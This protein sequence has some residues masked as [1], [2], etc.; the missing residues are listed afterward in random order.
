MED[1]KALSKL[2]HR[3]QLFMSAIFIL[4]LGAGRFFPVIGYLVPVC[5]A[6]GIYLGI[7]KGRIWC[8]YFCPRGSFLDTAGKAVSP[9]RKIPSFLKRTPFRT[10]VL[11]FMFSMMA[12][13]VARR[14]P[15]FRSIGFFFINL[16]SAVTLVGIILALLIHQRTWCTFCPV[17]SF[18]SWFGRGRNPMKIDSSL[19][20][21]CR[22]C[23]RVCPLQL[24]PYRFKS[25][26]LR[27]VKEKDC[28]KCGLCI[29]ACPKKALSQTRNPEA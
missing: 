21:E 10:A 18:S 23:S 29:A 5:M 26:G 1:Y 3:K 8:N 14:W 15:D 7:S 27:D 4:L 24:E 11:L 6:L 17:A 2:R 28:L 13:Q 22:L 12:L 16:L 19:C 9:G 25:E 20:V